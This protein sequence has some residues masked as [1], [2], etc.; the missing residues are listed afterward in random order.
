[1]ETNWRRQRGGKTGGELLGGLVW[2]LCVSHGVFLPTEANPV[3]N[4]CL[5]SAVLGGMLDMKQRLLEPGKLVQLF[6]TRREKI[7][8]RVWWLM[9]NLPAF[10]LL[11]FQNF[12]LDILLFATILANAEQNEGEAQLMFYLLSFTA[13]DCNL[14]LEDFFGLGKWLISQKTKPFKKKQIRLKHA[15]KQSVFNNNNKWNVKKN[16][17]KLQIF[18]R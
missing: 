13:D 7:I 15:M 1:M 5:S 6:W 2:C 3:Q 9:V 4:E 18:R 11:C 12:I 14:F 10:F 16:L 17:G 8:M